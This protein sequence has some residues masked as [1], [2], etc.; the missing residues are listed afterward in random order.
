MSMQIRLRGA[1]SGLGLGR[2]HTTISVLGS[3]HDWMLNDRLRVS[4]TARAVACAI[5]TQVQV[6]APFSVTN[7]VQVS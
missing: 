2:C 1:R 7:T 3:Q 5:V 6:F 4:G